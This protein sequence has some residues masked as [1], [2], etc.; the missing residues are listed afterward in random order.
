MTNSAAAERSV[1][2]VR[3]IEIWIERINFLASR[4]PE[5]LV[6]GQIRA[7]PA[8][9]LPVAR[10]TVNSTYGRTWDASNAESFSAAGPCPATS[11]KFAHPAGAIVGTPQSGAT[12]NGNES[13]AGRI[14]G[15]AKSRRANGIRDAA[16]C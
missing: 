13:G 12:G 1:K 10:P 14:G 5:T 16:A 8:T 6:K 2:R 15:P 11:A 9:C 7:R 4:V 3:F